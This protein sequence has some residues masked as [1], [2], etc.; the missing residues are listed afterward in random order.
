MCRGWLPLCHG[1]RLVRAL[2]AIEAVGQ[3]QFQDC[4]AN[5]GNFTASIFVLIAAFLEKWWL[6]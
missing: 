3:G 1:S 5:G 4:L 2:R 6:A